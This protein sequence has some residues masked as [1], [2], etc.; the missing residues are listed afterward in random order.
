MMIDDDH[1]ADDESSCIHMY[2]FVI[3]VDLEIMSDHTYDHSLYIECSIRHLSHQYQT[4]RKLHE[5]LV[6]VLQSIRTSYS[7][8]QLLS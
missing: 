8:Q 7:L 5:S 1:I 2:V 6:S 4:N 3:S